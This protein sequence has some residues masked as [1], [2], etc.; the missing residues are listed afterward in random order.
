LE[1]DEVACLTKTMLNT[2]GVIS[3]LLSCL[4]VSGCTTAPA[5]KPLDSNVSIEKIQAKDPTSPVFN[6]YLAQQGIKQ[7]NIPLKAWDIDTLTLSALF[8]HTKLDVAKQK[9]ALS[10]LAIQTAGIKKAPS[11]NAELAHSDQKNEDIKPWSYGLS[12]DIPIETNNKR[13]L[14][15]EKAEANM[16]S[17]RLDVAEIA[18]QLRNQ[19]AQDL[20]AYH[21]NQA[22]TQ[23]LQTELAIQQSIA[24]M[25]E[26]RVNAGIAS[27][28]ELN[29]ANLL[30][31]KAAHRLN[32]KLAQSKLIQL[33]I[34]TDA[35]LS[36]EKF[37]QIKIK[38]LQLDQALK[39][40]SA[41]LETSFES[42]TLQ[43]QA[44]L[45]RI[46][47]RRSLAQYA[48]AEIEIKLQAAKQTPDITLSPGILFEFG[49]KIWSLGFSSLLN[50]LQKNT[51]L[52]EKAKLLREIE[53]AAF[54]NLQ[55]D[56]IAKVNQSH[57]QYSASQQT[58]LQAKQQLAKQ[59]AQTRKMQKQFD[60]G[61][62]GKLDLT[63]YQRNTLV[64][65]QQFL[66]AQFALLKVAI[67]IE[68]VMQKPIY[69]AFKMPA[70]A[71]SKPV[72]KIEPSKVSPSDD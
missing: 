3:T 12:V 41:I 25:L 34:A 32:N 8:Y 59:R 67:R 38:P 48:A 40:Q 63:Q 72:N 46:D 14:R 58:M 42:K 19:I 37:S 21:Q 28:T 55:A 33:K 51:A 57:A 66:D 9:L 1:G 70:L 47:I 56:I 31:L 39:Q 11:I 52:I 4:F 20:M 50:M 61:L 36:V 29:N 6:Q 23:L 35:G 69:S 54:E 64:A 68:D 60:A 53:G 15:I 65:E 7:D 71:I 18:W 2:I 5:S 17:A 24:S 16:E 26:K 44:L 49:D 30:A 43:E 27:R 45:N 22:E 13:G 62:I 10:K